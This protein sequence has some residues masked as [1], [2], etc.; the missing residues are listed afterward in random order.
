MASGEK[1]VRNVVSSIHAREP[2]FMRYIHEVYVLDGPGKS[3]TKTSQEPNGMK[4]SSNTLP[5]PCVACRSA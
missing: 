5:Y 2:T 4:L 3:L 1:W